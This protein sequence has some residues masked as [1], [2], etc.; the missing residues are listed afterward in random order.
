MLA[1]LS[2][3]LLGH[4]VEMVGFGNRTGSQLPGDVI[5]PE[6]RAKPQAGDEPT[7]SGDFFDF[8]L[9]LAVVGDGGRQVVGLVISQL[10]ALRRRIVF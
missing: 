4:V 10:V 8:D 1:Q 6:D 2:P 5:A 3:I 9:P 7:E